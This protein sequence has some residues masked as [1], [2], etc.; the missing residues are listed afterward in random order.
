MGRTAAILIARLI[1]VGAFAMAAHL[2]VRL[3]DRQLHPPRA[4]HAAGGQP[5]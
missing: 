1:F 2:L 5:D 4:Q 3:E